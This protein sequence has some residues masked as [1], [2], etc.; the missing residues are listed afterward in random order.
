MNF[1][2]LDILKTRH[3][4]RSIIRC[5]YN[6]DEN[7]SKPYHIEDNIVFRLFTCVHSL[8]AKGVRPLSCI[9]FEVQ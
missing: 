1:G 6:P 4:T 2:R 9:V 7:L 5:P 3:I 8:V